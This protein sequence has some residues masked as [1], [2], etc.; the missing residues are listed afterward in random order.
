M[1]LNELK[2][3]MGLNDPKWAQKTL[4]IFK[5][6]LYEFKIAEKSLNELRWAL[7]R[8]NFNKVF[9]SDAYPVK[10]MT[11]QWFRWRLDAN[12]TLRNNKKIHWV[13]VF[14]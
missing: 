1:S 6:I 5:M 3:K 8:S 11:M 2:A 13:F 9:T 14:I 12:L 4:K 7:M 10:D